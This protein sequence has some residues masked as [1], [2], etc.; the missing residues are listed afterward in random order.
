MALIDDLRKQS[1]VV[2]GQV[3]ADK[4]TQEARVWAAN[5]ARLKDR[6]HQDMRTPE[7]IRDRGAA[8]DIQGGDYAD[9]HFVGY[10]AEVA[11]YFR[12]QG[13][14]VTT[15]GGERMWNTAMWVTW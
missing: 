5:V 7:A 12:Q 8:A 3:A 2:S 14:V 9:G 13:F 15:C 6:I 4:R 11:E 1:D 10:A